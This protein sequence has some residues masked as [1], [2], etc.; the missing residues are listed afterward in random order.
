MVEAQRR[1]AS[2]GPASLA[3]RDIGTVV[4][5]EAPV[6]LYLEASP[7]ARAARRSRQ[8]RQWGLA[9]EA[10]EAREDIEQRD[11]LDSSR[12]ASP[13]RPAEDAIVIDTTDLSLDD[14]IRFSL[15]LLGCT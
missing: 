13:L 10:E 12:A 7:E 9:Q 4:L 2:R 5:P 3:G 6:K 14:V 1:I 15:E 11:R 8:A